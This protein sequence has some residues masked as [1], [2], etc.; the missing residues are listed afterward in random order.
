MISHTHTT[1]NH[2]LSLDRR[3][4]DHTLFMGGSHVKPTHAN[5]TTECPD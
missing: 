3:D 5:V 4:K 1:E 2:A